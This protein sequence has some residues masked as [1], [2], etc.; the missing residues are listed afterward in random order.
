MNWA[1]IS[2]RERR[3]VTTSAL[4]I[5]ALLFGTK[6][7][8]RWQAARAEALSATAEM[9]RSVRLARN[10]VSAEKWL[11]DS[12]VSR[13]SS[14]LNLASRVLSERSIGSAG[15]ELAEIINVAAAAAG[16][17]MGSTYILSDT[18]RFRVFQ[19]VAVRTAVMGDIASVMRLL[20]ALEGGPTALAIRDLTISQL[21]TA[22]GDREPEMLRAELAVAALMRPSEE[23]A[24]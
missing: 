4:A 16:V 20:T 19:Q 11:R 22:S 6:V 21:N 23:S 1:G 15:A 9:K 8:P 14:F 7:L 18:I 3:M 5:A 10:L 2:E 13:G 17:R 24:R 12:A